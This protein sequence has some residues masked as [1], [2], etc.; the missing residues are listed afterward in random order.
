MV[1]IEAPK[2]FSTL[3]SSGILV[4]VEVKCWTA[5]KQDTEVSHEVTTSKKADPRSGKFITNLMA[6]V[7]EHKAVTDD[8]QS[9]YN[10]LQSI[11]YDY[12]G[13]L[14][15]LPNARIPM[16]ME[17][18]NQRLA[19]TKRLHEALFDALPTAIS[20]AAFTHGD[21]FKPEHYP[22]VEDVKSKC[23]VTLYTSDVADGDFRN[24]LMIDSAD[25]LKRHYESQV[26]S[27]IDGI[28]S[29]QAEQL[30][31]LMKSISHVCD[32]TTVNGKTNRPRIYDTTIQKA[33][34][35]CN[36]FKEFNIKDDEALERARAQLE[37]ALKDINVDALR[38]SDTMRTSVK[39]QL[40][41]ALSEYSKTQ[42]TLSKFGSVVSLED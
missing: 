16:F 41:Q 42:S 38:E 15:Y 35:Y 10:W 1:S 29:K 24:Q 33:L 37:A 39:T 31:S 21:L 19:N 7:P 28:M 23:R 34:E 9:W 13:S 2:V 26:N 4:H 40:D 22:T 6:N 17:Q 14:R 3:K 11:T 36:T 18:Y 27:I 8:R 12:R 5:T 25:E 32:V 20:N 30:I